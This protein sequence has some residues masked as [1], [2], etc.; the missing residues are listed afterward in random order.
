MHGILSN[1]KYV[2]DGQDYKGN[3]WLVHRDIGFP[4]INCPQPQTQ[5]TVGFKFRG[6]K[7]NCMN[8][9]IRSMTWISY[10]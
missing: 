7:K 4:K 1:I 9:L 10:V 3:S 6:K 2:Q 5:F 8:G